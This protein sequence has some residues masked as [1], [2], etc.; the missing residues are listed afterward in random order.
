[1]LERLGFPAVGHHRRFVTALGIDALGSGIWLPVSLIYFLRTTDVGLVQ[2]GLTLTIANLVLVPLGPVAGH[3]TDAVGPKRMIQAGNVLQ[4]ASFLAFPLATN[5]WL[6]GVLMG[7]ATLG[8]TMFWSANGPMITQITRA[9]EREQWFGFVHAMRNAGM[10][11]GGLLSAV[12]LTIGTDAA[13]HGVALAN[14]ASYAVSFLLMRGVSGGERP[15]GHAAVAAGGWA[16]LA[17]DRAYQV[18]VV[19]TFLYALTEMSLN[20]A[21]PVYFAEVLSLP[22]WVP[23]TV[24]VINTV[25]IGLGQGL[26]VRGMT[27]HVRARVLLT[28]I[29]C[30]ASSFLVFLVAGELT[31]PVATAIVLAGA[32]VYTLGELMVGPV[33]GALSA[34]T[35]PEEFRGRYMSATGL[36]WNCAG[37]IAP[38]CYTALLAR[39]SVATWGGAF[40]LCLA[41]AGSVLV[42]RRAMPRAGRPVTNAVEEELS[43]APSG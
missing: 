11:V 21:M 43:T 15:V 31:V 29:A 14:A 33:L 22:A 30:T 38:V 18:L 40:L 20:V 3:L 34:E 13:L 41:W 5:V 39:G 36:A 24:F 9:G 6:I 28:G 17:R 32:F 4:C 10:G 19:C 27:G 35:A 7:A 23:G 8:R 16:A 42:L 12:A 37:A 2:L 26:V 1:M 25:M